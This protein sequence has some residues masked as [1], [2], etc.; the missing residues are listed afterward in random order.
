M[1]NIDLFPLPYLRLVFELC[2]FASAFQYEFMFYFL[3]FDHG[4]IF[5]A[6]LEFLG[7]WAG[8]RGVSQGLVEFLGTLVEP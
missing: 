7:H 2:V 4:R 5:K 6:N 3:S 1:A 8:G